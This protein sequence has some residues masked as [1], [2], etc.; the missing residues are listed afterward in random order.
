MRRVLIAGC[1]YVGTALGRMLAADGGEVF[2][3]RRSPG[4]LPD[5]IEPV[6]AD[7]TDPSSLDALPTDL[8]AIAVTVS[9]DGRTE[10]AYR[11]AYVDSLRNLLDLLAAQGQTPA[12]IVFTSSTGV[13]RQSG[14]EEVDE[15][16]PTQPASSTGRILLEA[17]QTLLAAPFPAVVL[18]LAGIYGPGRTRL[19]DRVRDGSARC[20]EGAPVWTNRIHRDDCAGA[21]RHLLTLEDPEPVYLGVDDDTADRCEVLR[22]LADRIGVAPP[23]T[24]AAEEAGRSRGGS[25][26]CSNDRLTGSGYRLRYPSYRDG[27]AEMLA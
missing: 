3:L 9:A 27:Y 24:V 8:D 16:S 14:G 19:I 21:L 22:W 10:A 13:Y 15:T 4:K 17:E 25:K 26:R 12:R 1:G 2:G 18:R 5:G 20:V 7:L 11:A 6:L 23:P